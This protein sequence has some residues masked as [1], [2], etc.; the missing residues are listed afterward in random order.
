MSIECVSLIMFHQG[1]AV[2]LTITSQTDWLFHE[3]MALWKFII[4]QQTTFRR[5]EVIWEPD[6]VCSG[7]DS[8]LPMQGAWVPS[9]VGELDPT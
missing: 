5:K 8:T 4:C 1:S 3:Q 7:W 9:L 6:L 2:W